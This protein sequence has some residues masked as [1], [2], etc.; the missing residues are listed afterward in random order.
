MLY[1]IVGAGHEDA[2]Q[3]GQI[4]L[5]LK[6]LGHGSTGIEKLSSILD[7]NSYRHAQDIFWDG[8]LNDDP[9]GLRQIIVAEI[10]PSAIWV[11]W[12][13]ANRSYSRNK[14]LD[15]QQIMKALVDNTSEEDCIYA[16]QLVD[17]HKGGMLGLSNNWSSS[18]GS[19]YATTW[20]KISTGCRTIQTAEC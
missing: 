17:L 13:L 12:L 2:A 5:T 19:L 7:P 18:I 8:I 9:P 14:Y 20:I 1:L 15:V 11:E 4:A 6:I 3:Q 10:K 16:L